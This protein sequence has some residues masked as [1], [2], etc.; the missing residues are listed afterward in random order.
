MHMRTALYGHADSEAAH[1]DTLHRVIRP[2]GA[3]SS[4]IA[5]DCPLATGGCRLIEVKWAF[6]AAK[7]ASCCVS[8]ERAI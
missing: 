2:R 3:T 5:P 6:D 1:A 8:G 7:A 4:K